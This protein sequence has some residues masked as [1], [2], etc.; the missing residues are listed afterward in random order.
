MK[1]RTQQGQ[2][3]SEYAVVLGVVTLGAI[4]ALAALGAR[5]ADAF[6]A[7]ADAIS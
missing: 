3:L 1:I 7:V 5:L 2:A 6:A 4:V